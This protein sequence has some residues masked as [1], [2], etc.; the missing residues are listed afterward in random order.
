MAGWTPGQGQALGEATDPG[1][2]VFLLSRICCPCRGTRRRGLATITSRT[3]PTW[4]CSLH[5]L[6]SF[7]QSQA[8]TAQH[9][10]CHGI[11]AHVQR[12]PP[13]PACRAAETPRSPPF[14]PSSLDMAL[15]GSNTQPWLLG[16]G[17]FVFIVFYLCA[18]RGG[19]QAPYISL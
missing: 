3:L 15:P 13:H 2:F 19:L 11:D 16:F 4:A 5:F 17:I 12:A 18:Q 9:Y 1:D 8:P 7:R 10:P 6:S 14:S